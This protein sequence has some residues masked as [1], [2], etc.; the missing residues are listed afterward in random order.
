MI[1]AKVAK[2]LTDTVGK[3]FLENEFIS[4]KGRAYQQ[5][6]EMAERGWTHATINGY[7]HPELPD[8]FRNLGFK[9][10]EEPDKMW[11]V[12]SWDHV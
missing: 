8:L 2:A 1:D 6:R 12:V 9:V 7:R 3:Q 5:I 10:V 4:S 11:F